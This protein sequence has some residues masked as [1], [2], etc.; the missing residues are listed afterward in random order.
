MFRFHWTFYNAWS[1]N[2]KNARLEAKKR[3]VQIRYV[4]EIT[5]DNINYSK[6]MMSLF[7]VLHLQGMKGNF[8]IYDSKICVQVCREC[9][10]EWS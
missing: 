5:K 8:E 9:A 2:D 3:G 10:E 6:E 1:R 7:E 4:T